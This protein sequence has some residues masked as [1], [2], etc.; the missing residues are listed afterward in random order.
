MSKKNIIILLLSILF[1]CLGVIVYLLAMPAEKQSS[2]FQTTLDIGGVFTLTNQNNERVS[3]D[4]YKDKYK[5]IYFGFTFCPAICP[6]ELQKISTAL[7]LLGD[8]ASNIQPIFISVDPE[9]DTPAVLKSYVSNFPHNLTGFTGSTNDIEKVKKQFRIYAA[10]VQDKSSNEYTVDHSSYIY[11]LDKDSKMVD[12]YNH[13]DTSEVI[14]NRI[15]KI[16]ASQ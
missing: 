7:D 3:S 1:L 8:K 14:A 10:R 11:L 13:D 5:I 9:R 15:K 16:L 6:T 2:S 4:I 12:L